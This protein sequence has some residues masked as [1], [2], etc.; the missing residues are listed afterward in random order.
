MVG[1][2]PAIVRRAA[3]QSTILTDR[4]ARFAPLT[5]DHFYTTRL[6]CSKT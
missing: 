4:H 2:I 5:T 6:P 3:A 1:G